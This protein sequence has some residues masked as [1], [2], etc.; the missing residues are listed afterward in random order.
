MK[1]GITHELILSVTKTL[2]KAT[3]TYEKRTKYGITVGMAAVDHPDFKGT[4]QDL[5]RLH[6][7]GPGHLPSR[8][9]I[10]P[11]DSET[12]GKMDRSLRRAHAIEVNKAN[13]KVK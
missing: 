6:A 9:I 2:Y 13:R 7:A 1:Y 8:V 3:G 4:T 10:V 12:K 5:A 11:A